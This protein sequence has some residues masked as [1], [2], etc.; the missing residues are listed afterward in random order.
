M[1]AT[2]ELIGK[3]LPDDLKYHLKKYVAQAD[4][5]VAASRHGISLGTV[6]RIFRNN[7]PIP[8]SARSY[9]AIK[10]LIQIALER[11]KEEAEE[12]K[13]SKKLLSNLA[14]K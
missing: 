7:D 14:K 12:A 1:K 11:I 9:P 13:V 3:C 5:G 2:E 6:D 8:I 10:D 4:Y